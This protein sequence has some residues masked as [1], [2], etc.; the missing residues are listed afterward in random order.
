[1]T[2]P[3]PHKE[4]RDGRLWQVW[5][6]I[7]EASQQV[8]GYLSWRDV[9]SGSSIK[10]WAEGYPQ[11]REKLAGPI[12]STFLLLES[13]GLLESEDE[14]QRKFR[15]TEAGRTL[16]S[17]D[18]PTAQRGFRVRLGELW[19]AKLGASSRDDF[20]RRVKQQRPDADDEQ[21][22]ATWSILKAFDLL[23][24]DA[25]PSCEASE[26]TLP[27]AE[28]VEAAPSEV[29]AAPKPP[30]EVIDAALPATEAKPSAP[31]QEANL[32]T[33]DMA[34]PNPLSRASRSKPTSSVEDTVAETP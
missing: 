6:F 27:P 31:N 28:F 7:L 4:L 32:A 10:S 2:L 20:A 25:T 16:A 34:L 8:E 5:H 11:L 18:E 19:F 29:E 23:S 17:Q 22:E 24:M 21:I 1:M 26:D 3:L 12:N 33:D 9:N 13:L 14:T 30:A 15:L